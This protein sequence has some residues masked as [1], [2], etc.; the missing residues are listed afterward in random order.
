VEFFFDI[1]TA[2]DHTN[3]GNLIGLDRIKDQMETYHKAT[4]PGS[5]ARTFSANEWK[6]GQVLEICIDSLN[7]VISRIRTAFFEIPIDAKQVQLCFIRKK[8][9]HSRN[10]LSF[11]V[12]A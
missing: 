9:D 1:H 4:E 2:V 5:K 3:D 12:R 7:E 6:S 10:Y 8:N 11:V